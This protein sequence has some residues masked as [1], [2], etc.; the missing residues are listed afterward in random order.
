M[1]IY[2]DRYT[3]K[4]VGINIDATDVYLCITVPDK[5]NINK[6][7]DKVI[8]E[9]Y[10][11]DKDSNKPLYRID[12]YEETT[13]LDE[14]SYPVLEFIKEKRE[15]TLESAFEEF[16]L[17]DIVTAKYRNIL[18][19]SSCDYI[20]AQ[21]F[22]DQGINIKDEH[23]AANTGIG[24]IQLLPKGQAKTYLIE[25]DEVVNTIEL[26]LYEGDP[27]VELYVNDVKVENNKVSLSSKTSSITVTFKN[28]TDKALLINAYALG[29]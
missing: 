11:I 2:V 17:D 5:L 8:G 29:Y 23:H 13:T 16:T 4:V 20:I 27:Q 24:F 1:Q 28:P 19:K 25:L 6:F 22:I 12:A 21:E 26:L 10:V 7:I 9:K 18:E 14:T 3:N 15:M